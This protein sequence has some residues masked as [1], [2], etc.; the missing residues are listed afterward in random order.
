VV[1][2]TAFCLLLSTSYSRLCSSGE[3]WTLT[4]YCSLL[5]AAA[6]MFIQRY[7]ASMF[8]A[9]TTS[10][11]QILRFLAFILLTAVLVVMF[12]VVVL[13]GLAVAVLGI[14]REAQDGAT[15]T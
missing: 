7:L 4:K 1:T 6:T 5:D 8:T 12:P 13:F 15:M 11:A 2:T 9:F 3:S 10:V 14:W